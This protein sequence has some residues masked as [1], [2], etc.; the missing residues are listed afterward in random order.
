MRAVILVRSVEIW[1]TD[2]NHAGVFLS[3]TA[4]RSC[5]STARDQA[6]PLSRD[7]RV[8]RRDHFLEPA[9][10]DP[11]YE[12]AGETT[13]YE[14]SILRERQQV[15]ST[16]SS[17]RERQHVTNPIHITYRARNLVSLP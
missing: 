6:L 14:P 2:Q 15:T 16:T 3:G 13:G 7:R 12:P 4:A 10:R 9:P 5:L 17:L 11:G 1:V 8:A